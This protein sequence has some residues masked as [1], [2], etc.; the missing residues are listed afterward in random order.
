MMPGFAVVETSALPAYLDPAPLR[1]EPEPQESARGFLLRVA[2]RNLCSVEEMNR[3]LGLP[4]P[5]APLS[6]D[7]TRAA[8]LLAVDPDQLE[9]MGF[10]DAET[11]WVLGH[12][13]SVYHLYRTVR[14]FCPDCLAEEP[15]YRRI[16]DLRQIDCCPRHSRQLADRCHECGASSRWVSQWSHT[17]CNCGAS[18]DRPGTSSPVEDCTG[19]RAIYLHCRLP[20]GGDAGRLPAVFRALPLGSLLDLLFF[21]GRMDVIVAS[22]NPD[23]MPRRVMLKDRGILNAGTRIALGWPES[24]DRLAARVR[25]SRPEVPGVMRQY[26]YLHR[27]IERAGKEPYADLLREAYARHLSRLGDVPARSWPSFLPPCDDPIEA[28]TASAV[29]RALGIGV[30]PFAAL[31]KQKLW[32]S[33]RPLISTPKGAPQYAPADVAMLRTKLVDK[34]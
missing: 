14:C 21:F 34:T 3:W 15:Y 18:L 10:E 22:G 13:V 26:G 32:T 25:A 29:Q 6:D 27:F 19:A 16:W 28:M 33:I 9:R 11:G 2:A 23:D 31:R 30:K 8:R 24:F 20:A 4:A 1:V 7:L 12:K 17:F 5:S